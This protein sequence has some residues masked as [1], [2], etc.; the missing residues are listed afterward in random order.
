[1]FVFIIEEIAISYFFENAF[2]DGKSHHTTKLNK[3]LP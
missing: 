2:L 1:M 3:K